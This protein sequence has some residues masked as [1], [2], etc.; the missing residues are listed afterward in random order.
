[1]KS[2]DSLKLFVGE[3]K[4]A[5]KP[6]QLSVTIRANGAQICCAKE[7]AKPEGS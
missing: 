6:Y 2:L 5:T 7:S 3:M 1:M 4:L